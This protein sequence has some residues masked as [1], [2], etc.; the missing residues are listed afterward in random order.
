MFTVERRLTCI[1]VTCIQRTPEE[2]T[3]RKVPAAELLRVPANGCGA[4]LE[5]GGRP[6]HLQQY[7]V[8]AR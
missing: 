5:F 4:E 2:R 6:L 7:I 8:T 3:Y 1:S